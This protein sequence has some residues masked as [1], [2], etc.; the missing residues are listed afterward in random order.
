MPRLSLTRLPIRLRLT[1]LFTGVMAI[2]LAALGGFLYLRFRSDLDYNIDQSLRARAQEISN[3]VRNE[4]LAHEQGPGEALP[5]HGQNFVQILDRRGG[6]RA[7]SAGLPKSPLLSATEITRALRGPLLLQR[8]ERQRMYAMPVQGGRS[9]V[10]AGVLLAERD[11]AFDKLEDALL[12]G[13]PLALALA[14][15]AAYGLAA[16]AL[17]PVESMRRRA[18]TI[19]STD[20]DARLPLPQSVDEIHRLGATLNEMLDRLRDGL[21]R[22][23]SFLADASHELR[24]PLAVLKAELEVTLREKGSTGQLRAAV[25]SAVE[26]ADHIIGLA[27]DLLVLARAEQGQISIQ[28]RPVTLEELMWALSERLRPIAEHAG[29]P[30]LVSSTGGPETVS[31][32]LDR[33]GQ[34]LSNLLDNAL[35]YGRGQVRFKA[36]LRERQL[37]LHVTDEGPGFAAEFLP[38]AFE[39]FSRSDPARSR[40]GAG[41]GLAIVQMIAHA[42]HG[43]AHAANQPSG[44]ADVWLSIPA[45]SGGRPS[46]SE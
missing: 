24:T 36:T 1:L 25:A 14:F 22:E 5:G 8:G 29:R 11:A 3:L 16:A 17:R 38:R 21:E 35:R 26:E 19:S 7:A 32:D 31:A 39:R 9:I 40:G 30:L 33:L 18:A 6:V 41:L 43:A 12:T 13:G 20:T 28:P 4:A 34:A 44:G 23:R 15:A 46:L 45:E 42:H 10:V 2:L 37:E 27:E